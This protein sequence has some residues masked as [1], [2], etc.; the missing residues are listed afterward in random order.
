MTI[1]FI[2][3]DPF[4]SKYSGKAQNIFIWKKHVLWTSTWIL[5]SHVHLKFASKLAPPTTT[6]FSHPSKNQNSEYFAATWKQRDGSLNYGLFCKL[7]ESA[8][9][10]S[11]MPKVQQ[12]L[13]FQGYSNLLLQSICHSRTQKALPPIS[14]CIWR[15]PYTYKCDF[16]SFGNFL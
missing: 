1:S 12:I 10:F 15:P 7:R 2:Q 9:S 11:Q 8:S 13:S 5:D 3:V 14:Q 6:P 4:L 16:F